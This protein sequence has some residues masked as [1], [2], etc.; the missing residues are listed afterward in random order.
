MPYTPY[1]TA[2]QWQTFFATNGNAR[3][4]VMVDFLGSI[5]GGGYTPTNTATGWQNTLGNNIP[6][7][8]QIAVDTLGEQTGT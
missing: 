1:K 4:Q 6:Q 8:W 3:E 5:E 2:T 7:D